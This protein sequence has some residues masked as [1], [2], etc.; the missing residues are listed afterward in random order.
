MGTIW[1]KFTL[2]RR[3]THSFTVN[4]GERILTSSY[5]INI[6]TNANI[7]NTY[8]VIL[9]DTTISKYVVSQANKF[10]W[11]VHKIYLDY[12]K[13]IALFLAILVLHK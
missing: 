11:A 4:Q 10:R 7:T 6:D 8:K 12:F 5:S 13:T 3:V 2:R 9:L 1:F